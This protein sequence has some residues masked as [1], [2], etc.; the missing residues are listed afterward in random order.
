MQKEKRILSLLGLVV[1][2]VILFGIVFFKY[3]ADREQDSTVATVLYIIVLIGSI[4]SIMLYY[5]NTIR[6]KD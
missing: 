1:T 5:I 2:V 6:D 3:M 4:S